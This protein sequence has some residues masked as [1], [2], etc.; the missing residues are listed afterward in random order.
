MKQEGTDENGDGPLAT[1]TVASRDD[2]W[3]A[4][5]DVDV[6]FAASATLPARPEY[7][8]KVFI[9][10]IALGSLRRALAEA[11]QLARRRRL[12][13]RPGRSATDVAHGDSR[14]TN[15]TTNIYANMEQ[16]P[17]HTAKNH[18]WSTYTPAG[19]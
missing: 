18:R 11:A 3:A 15:H 7:E 4:A 19:N 2:P 13:R 14:R 8:G 6:I 16:L 5:M 1:E 10:Y 9:S 17:L 12:S